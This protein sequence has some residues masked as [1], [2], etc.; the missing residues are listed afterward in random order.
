MPGVEDSLLTR[1]TDADWRELGAKD[2]Y[3]GVISH[4]RYHRENLTPDALDEFYASGTA[5]IDAV[6]AKLGWLTGRLPTGRALDF[7][8][9]VGRLTEAMTRYAQ[10]VTGYDISPG[11]LEL[12]RGRNGR[13]SYV[14]ELPEGPFDWINS[15]IV[16]QHIPPERGLAILGQLLARLAPDGVVSLHFTIWREQAHVWPAWTGWRRL[17]SPILKWRWRRRLQVGQILMFDY[18]LSQ[19][20]CHLDEAGV[21]DIHLMPTNHGGHHGVI[22]LGRKTAEANSR[23][24]VS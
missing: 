2:P 6:A 9:G 23:K 17:A 11:M 4:P 3:W 15:F 22:V 18:E 10:R 5:H 14:G 20:V 19:V 16:F 13:A 12:A 21:S 1:D 24:D 8:C 7:G